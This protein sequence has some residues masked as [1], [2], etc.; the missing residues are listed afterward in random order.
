[1]LRNFSRLILPL[2]KKFASFV[3]KH[4]LDK[5]VYWLQTK[6]HSQFAP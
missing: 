5:A 6:W 3:V 4:F 1:M 2:A